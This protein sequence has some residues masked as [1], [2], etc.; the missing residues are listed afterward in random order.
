[1]M[2]IKVTK[3]ELPSCRS[4]VAM[5]RAFQTWAQHHPEY[6]FEIEV[7]DASDPKYRDWLVDEIGV[8][9]APAYFIEREGEEPVWVSGMNTDALID[10]LDGEADFW[11]ENDDVVL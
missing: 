3:Y 9:S 5:G 7:R 8:K 6:T 10:A 1:M 2:K 4:C 11:L